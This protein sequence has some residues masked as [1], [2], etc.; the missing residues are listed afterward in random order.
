[1]VREKVGM[2]RERERGRHKTVESEE[3]YG[4]GGGR[5]QIFSN[6]TYGGDAEEGGDGS[7]GSAQERYSVIVDRS[8]EESP[9]RAPTGNQQVV[10]AIRKKLAKKNSKIDKNFRFKAAM[11]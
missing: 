1:M 9:N 2:V 8:D 3:G 11:F 10:Q 7:D 4:R 5:K 6:R